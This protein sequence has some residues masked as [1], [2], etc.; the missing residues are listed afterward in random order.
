MNDINLSDY[1]INVSD[2]NIRQIIL[3]KLYKKVEKLELDELYKF[4]VSLKRYDKKQIF[5]DIPDIPDY[6]QVIKRPMTFNIILNKL[7]KKLK[8]L[9]NEN[10]TNKTKEQ[11]EQ[12]L[13]LENKAKEQL[14]TQNEEEQGIN[15]EVVTKQSILELIQLIFTNA[16]TYNQEND[17]VYRYSEKIEK[18]YQLRLLN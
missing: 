18:E 2:E 11:S 13:G 12:L 9:N 10:N 7:D 1:N 6:T 3:K 4:I 16:Y 17:W 5:Y 14:L 8:S 15:N